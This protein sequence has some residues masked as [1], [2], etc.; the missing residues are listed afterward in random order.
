[1]S[2]INNNSTNNISI[3]LQTNTQ[4]K[5][6]SQ[7]YFEILGVSENA[8]Q[9]EINAAYLKLIKQAKTNKNI[10]TYLINE[11][12]N[13]L[14]NPLERYQYT[15]S[16]Q[17]INMNTQQE[18]S[19]DKLYDNKQLNKLILENEKVCIDEETKTIKPIECNEEKIDFESSL[20]Q[21]QSERVKQL[22]DIHNDRNQQ[23]GG[24]PSEQQIMNDIQNQSSINGFLLNDEDDNNF[25]SAFDDVDNDGYTDSGFTLLK[26]IEQVDNANKMFDNNRTKMEEAIKSRN[27]DEFMRLRAEEKK[28][29]TK[30]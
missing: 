22:Q 12:Y 26:N 27:I 28:I 19:V 29:I 25:K 18:N 1:M 13:V 20:K 21:L 9:Q 14:K 8:S 6:D 10:N 23:F 16:L 24:Q 7:N 17:T 11:A 30:Y 15:C 3:K 5:I 4:T 2:F